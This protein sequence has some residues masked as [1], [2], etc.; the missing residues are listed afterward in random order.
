MAGKLWLVATPIGNLGDISA[1][2]LEVLRTA[3]LI[4]AEDTRNTIR[5]LNHFGIKKPLTSYHEYNKTEKAYELVREAQEGKNIAVVT[6]AGMPA[7][8][9]PGEVLV[10]IACET[11][12]EVTIIPG[13][14]ACV[15]ALAI[16]GLPTRRFAFE[17]FLPADKGERAA[18]L[19]E[20]QRETRTIV[21]Y[22]APHHLLK[23]LKELRDCLGE[24]RRI[25]QVRELTK[26]HEEVRRSTLGEAV[27]LYEAPG[28]A[29][30][31]RGEYVLVIEGRDPEESRREEAARWESMSVKDHVAMYE[32]QG[33]DR[34]EA[35]RAAAKDRGVS[36]R[37][38]YQALL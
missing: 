10:R 34:K 3:D 19:Q 14:C 37:D 22:E 9:D 4:A 29:E 13:A 20:L 38:I 15:S 18:V 25:S 32:D 33:M 7:I 5:L 23:T 24:D 11:G 30:L 12:T 8:S 17:A 26:I 1:R 31:I 36:R 35:M 27:A 6:D 21:L 2:A 28:G 16:S